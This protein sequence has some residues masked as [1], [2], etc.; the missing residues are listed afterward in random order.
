MGIHTH[1]TFPRVLVVVC[2][3]RGIELNVGEQ[4]ISEWKMFY[5]G[6]KKIFLLRLVTMKCEKVGVPHVDTDEVLHMDPPISPYFDKE[7]L[8]FLEYEEEDRIDQHQSG[9]YGVI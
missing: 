7:R 5:R 8:Y 1:V 4:I 3:I 2:T 9:G 6:N